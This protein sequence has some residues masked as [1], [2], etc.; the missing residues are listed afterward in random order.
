LEDLGLLT[1]VS[2]TV[3]FKV[4]CCFSEDLGLLAEA[5]PDSTEAGGTSNAGNID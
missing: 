2:L 5:F 4:N 1:A 3:G